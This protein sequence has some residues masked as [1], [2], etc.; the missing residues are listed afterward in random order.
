MTP[1]PHREHQPS[2]RADLDLGRAGG[3]DELG[4]GRGDGRASGQAPAV[5]VQHDDPT[6]LVAVEV[7]EPVEH[8]DGLEAGRH[9]RGREYA[10]VPVY[11]V[12]WLVT[13]VVCLVTAVLLLLSGY[14]GYAGVAVAVAAS[15]AINLR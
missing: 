7:G 15:A 12:A 6:N 5:A 11:R 10:A 1:S 9:R 2:L 4:R 8:L 13:V 3:T 14:Q